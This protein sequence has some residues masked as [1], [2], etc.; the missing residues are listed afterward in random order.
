MTCSDYYP[1]SSAYLIQKKIIMVTQDKFEKLLLCQDIL[2]FVVH[3]GALHGQPHDPSVMNLHQ[4]IEDIYTMHQELS[5]ATS[6]PFLAQ[7]VQEIMI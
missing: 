4:V 6:P 7:F 1:L 2:S 5:N 3:F